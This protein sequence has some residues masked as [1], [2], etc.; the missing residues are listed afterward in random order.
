M[1]RALP[2]LALLGGALLVGGC[3][4]RAESES[5]PPAPNVSDVLQAFESPTLV[6]D[7][8][9]GAVLSP[10]IEEAIQLIEGLDLEGEVLDPIVEAL[11]E[12]T[13]EEL[14][15][16]DD[17]ADALFHPEGKPARVRRIEQPAVLEGDGFMRITRICSGWG[18]PVVDEE[19]NGQVVAILGFTEDGVDPVLWA[20][21]FACRY[22]TALGDAELSP[23]SGERG[24][25]VILALGEAVPAQELVGHPIVFIVDVDAT[26][27]GEPLPIRLAFRNVYG[28]PRYELLLETDSGTAVLITEGDS[29][30]GVRAENGTFACSAEEGTC[31]DPDGSRFTF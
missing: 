29:L 8:D 22:S 28:D 19:Q 15:T 27:D 17:V 24:A 3:S 10:F 2:A 31:T 21:F 13:G 11:E 9:V 23:G 6:V 1:K 7:D 18:E 16:S 5:K 20:D 14:D 25:Q 26:I 30:V 4:R 12:E